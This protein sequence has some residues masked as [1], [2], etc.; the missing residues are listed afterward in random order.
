[1]TKILQKIG[2]CNRGRT[3][4]QWRLIVALVCFLPFFLMLG[5]ACSSKDTD[6]LPASEKA[7]ETQAAE[8][9]AAEN[10][11]A[12]DQADEI[13]TAETQMAEEI[14]QKQDLQEQ[15]I[16]D[17][18]EPSNPGVRRIEHQL[19]WDLPAVNIAVSPGG[20]LHDLLLWDDSENISY[21]E[22]LIRSENHFGN[23]KQGKH[24]DCTLKELETRVDTQKDVS[25]ET[26]VLEELVSRLEHEK[27]ISGLKIIGYA[28]TGY[29]N[30]ELTN[31]SR[32][33]YYPSQVSAGITYPLFGRL[34]EQR[35]SLSALETD[36]KNEKHIIAIKRS[37]A[38]ETLRQYL[39]SSVG[40]R[41][42]GGPCQCLFQ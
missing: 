8:I 42:E 21:L 15:D 14:S 33:E 16:A 4:R 12:K 3:D 30:E 34:T 26:A 35:N 37:N 7:A 39:H 2:P 13:R 10:Q 38:L 28:R 23:I 18:K 32:R 24:K 9:E 20:A 41:A 1:M 11:A 27:G 36:I 25:A 6:A 40:Q 22:R 5:N 17:K 29:T 31:G 19:L